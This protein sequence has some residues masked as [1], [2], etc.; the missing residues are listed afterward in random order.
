[1]S[2]SETGCGEAGAAT[3]SDPVAG[4]SPDS[5][6]VGVAFSA[7]R[8]LSLA[9][10][11]GLIAAI[12]SWMGGE[13][14]YRRFIPPLIATGGF[15]T[16]EETE[17]AERA[18]RNGVA[19]EAALTIAMQ[20]A[21]LGLTLSLAGAMLAGRALSGMRTGLAG[22]V[23]GGLAPGVAAWGLMPVFLR[24]YNPDKD[25]LLLAMAIHG[26]V[27]MVTGAA[28]GLAFG[29]GLSGGGGG[30]RA[31]FVSSSLQGGLLGAGVAM[32]IFQIAGMVVFPLSQTTLPISI[33]QASRLTS[34]LLVA[35]FAAAGAARG[36]IEI[37]RNKT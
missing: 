8:C 12:A 20:G 29:L 32:L 16:I 33:T 21:A 15:P 18:R 36:A 14:I 1:M 11:A 6:K 3:C 28:A 26:C 17:A 24:Y 4:E 22:M 27:A 7:R 9:L 34:H 13:S 5:L 25:M 35:L 30:R 10:L 31:R 23:I 19:T 37:Q 2:L